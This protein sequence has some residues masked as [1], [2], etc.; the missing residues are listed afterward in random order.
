MILSSLKNTL[1]TCNVWYKNH[2]VVFFHDHE[3]QEDN[4]YKYRETFLQDFLE[5][6]FFVLRDSAVISRYFNHTLFP[7][8]KD[9]LLV[10]TH[11]S[12]IRLNVYM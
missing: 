6:V 5:N 12:H 11:R 4:Y 2:K 10:D 7:I 8:A 1:K 9:L 3:F